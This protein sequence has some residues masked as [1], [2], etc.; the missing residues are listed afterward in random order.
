[1]NLT[2]CKVQGY[3]FTHMNLFENQVFSI[4]S[5]MFMSYKLN[6]LTYLNFLIEKTNFYYF[7]LFQY[8][9]LEINI[10]KHKVFYTFIWF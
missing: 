2:L 3:D 1:M 5:I 9:F 10:S 8:S 6:T 7:R 4:E